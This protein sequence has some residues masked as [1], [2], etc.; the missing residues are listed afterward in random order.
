RWRVFALAASLALGIG[1][2]GVYI[3]QAGML[4][5][6]GYRTPVGGIESVPTADGSTITL[7]T[8]SQIRVALSASERRIEL[9]HGEAYFEVAHDPNRPFVVHAGN[10]RVIAVGTKFSVRRDYDD[11]QVV[12]TEG[13]VRL[14]GDDSPQRPVEKSAR[15]RG[16]GA[17]AAEVSA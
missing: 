6:D 12:V 15:R 5:R 8:D 17:G 4:D 1:G 14:E 7:N 2:S 13:K 11:V 9:K 3:Y 16:P 10:K